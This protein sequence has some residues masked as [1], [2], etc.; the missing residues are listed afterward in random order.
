MNNDDP[1]DLFSFDLNAAY[2]L[3]ACYVNPN[4]L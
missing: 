2:F 3:A 4:A 1:F